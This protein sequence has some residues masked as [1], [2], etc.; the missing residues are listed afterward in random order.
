LLDGQRVDGAAT[1]STDGTLT[2]VERGT[3]TLVAEVVDLAGRILGS[4]ETVTFNVN[5]TRVKPTPQPR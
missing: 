3:H 5:Q 4:S 2:G 1:G